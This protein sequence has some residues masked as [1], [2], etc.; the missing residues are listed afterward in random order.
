MVTTVRRRTS[1]FCAL[2]TLPL[3]ISTL[4][5]R[6]LFGARAH[7]VPSTCWEHILKGEGVHDQPESFVV[8]RGL[9][10]QEPLRENFSSSA[11]AFAIL[12]YPCFQEF[13]RN[14][15]CNRWVFF[16]FVFKI[17]LLVSGFRDL[18]RRWM[19]E[20]SQTIESPTSVA[21]SCAAWHG[22]LCRP[23]GYAAEMPPETHPKTPV[24]GAGACGAVA[25][26]LDPPQYFSLHS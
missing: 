10:L 7:L 18:A 24:G 1:C 6:K 8:E 21:V 14:N 12:I 23:T 9:G 3:E 26:A 16:G 2:G 5:I 20:A 4:V 25:G 13:Q 19:C 22:G 15:S 17:E 11:G